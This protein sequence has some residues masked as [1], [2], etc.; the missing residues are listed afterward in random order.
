MQ[1]RKMLLQRVLGAVLEYDDVIG[2]GGN[3]HVAESVIDGIS[4]SKRPKYDARRFRIR[5]LLMNFR[6]LSA[7]GAST[8][9]PLKT[10]ALPSPR[11][12]A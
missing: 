11:H 7:I 5:N 4:G 1:I 2:A 8:N 9:R 12:N 10:P 3:D 6:F